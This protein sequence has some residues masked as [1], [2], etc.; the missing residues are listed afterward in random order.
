M[1]YVIIFSAQFNMLE[2]R[3]KFSDVIF[4]AKIM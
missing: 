4:G 2:N 3:P 1:R